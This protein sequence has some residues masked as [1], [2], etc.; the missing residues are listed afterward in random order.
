MGLT[1]YLIGVPMPYFG[2]LRGRIAFN[3][4]CRTLCGD[5]MPSALSLAVFEGWLWPI[6]VVGIF[7][8]R[9]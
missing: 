7:V 6:L 4:L 3:S 8:A 9:N 2:A 1:L 5:D